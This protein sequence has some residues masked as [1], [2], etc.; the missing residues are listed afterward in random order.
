M[1]IQNIAKV[2]EDWLLLENTYLDATNLRRKYSKQYENHI[3]FAHDDPR[4]TA[5]VREFYEL[6]IG[7]MC[8]RTADISKN[9]IGIK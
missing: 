6:A 2:P 1:A 8:Q 9:V 3:M 4:T 5:A 7:F